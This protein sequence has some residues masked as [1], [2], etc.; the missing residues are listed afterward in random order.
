[1]IRIRIDDVPVESG[2][3]HKGRVFHQIKKIHRW[4]QKISNKAVHVPTLLIKDIAEWPELIEFIREETRMYRM[5]PQIHGY[6][7]IDYG[8]LSEQE[9]TNHMRM[10]IEW[11]N[12]ELDYHP[13]IW[14]T[15]W[16]ATSPTM[17]AVGRKLGLTI[18]TTHTT[19]SPGAA[20]KLAEDYGP[21]IL[22][23]KT[24]ME[25]WYKRGLQLLRVIEIVEY[26]SVEEAKKQNP[27]IWK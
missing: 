8:K 9:I 21:A 3:H 7:H 19:L 11:F 27:E 16:G 10:C 6:E 18:E 5:F 23:G 26:G 22:R 25:H 2:A 17:Q 1:M 12:D 14:A 24:I 20:R 15:P 13:T 4:T